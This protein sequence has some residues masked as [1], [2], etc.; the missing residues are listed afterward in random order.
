MRCEEKGRYVNENDC[1]ECDMRD[2]EEFGRLTEKR[3]TT[4]FVNG[5]YDVST[6]QI[7]DCIR[8]ILKSEISKQFAERSDKIM[9]TLFEM[10]VIEE[11][12][13]LQDKDN[14]VKSTAKEL[15]TSKINDYL[16]TQDRRGRKVVHE[17]LDKA[18]DVNV[19]ERVG[20]AVEEIKT[21]CLEKFN[22]A[23]M[24]KMMQGM[25]K[26]IGDDQK[27]LTIITMGD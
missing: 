15:M 19:S 13:T 5:L 9:T 20:E 22:K 26:A 24:K 2:C 3:D 25:A 8:I 23:A 12:E 7:K 4:E 27:L 1:I 18:I 21:E 11:I 10:A 16:S 17:T 6:Q 14:L